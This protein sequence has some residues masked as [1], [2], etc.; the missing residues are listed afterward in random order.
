MKTI[1]DVIRVMRDL[2]L[3]LPVRD[4]LESQW[5]APGYTKTDA[6]EP[7]N[8]TKQPEPKGPRYRRRMLFCNPRRWPRSD[9]VH[10]CGMGFVT[11][12]PSEPK[13]AAG[14]KKN[15]ERIK[16]F[17]YAIVVDSDGDFQRVPV[18]SFDG[19]MPAAFILPGCRLQGLQTTAIRP[20][21]ESIVRLGK[22]EGK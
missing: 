1:K 20:N 22:S 21:C 16:L 3:R 19:G 14:V 17:G 15:M 12:I 7:I 2:E 13:F 4:G 9:P 10:C 5:D 18:I 11:R 8:P 6:L